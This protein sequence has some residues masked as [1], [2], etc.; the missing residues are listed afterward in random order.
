MHKAFK[1]EILNA[2]IL[3]ACS[4]ENRY[5]EG[6]T[7][8]LVER[9]TADVAAEG[10]ATR[11]LP[12]WPPSFCRLFCESELSIGGALSSGDLCSSF[13]CCN[14]SLAALL[15]IASSKC[16]A[17]TIILRLLNVRFE[18]FVASAQKVMSDDLKSETFIVV[19]TGFRDLGAPAG[20][21][22]PAYASDVFTVP[23]S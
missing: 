23:Y 8:E 21:E 10:T 15:A 14:F 11:E 4:S 12:D 22:T 1:L 18:M 19:L 17:L 2:K 7:T 20:G 5:D 3:V 16:S 6:V 9:T 13:G